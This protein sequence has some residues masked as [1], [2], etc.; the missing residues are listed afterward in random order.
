MR[1]VVV[2][3][4]FGPAI[5]AWLRVAYPRGCWS[6]RGIRGHQARLYVTNYDKPIHCFDCNA[7]WWT[8]FAPCWLLSA[9]FYKV[10]WYES[11]AMNS[12]I[13][14]IFC[15]I[16]ILFFKYRFW[17]TIA[18]HVVQRQYATKVWTQPTDLNRKSAYN[19]LVPTS[20]IAGF[21]STVPQRVEG[22]VDLGGR[23]L[24]RMV[25]PPADG[26]PSLYSHIE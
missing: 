9:P 5:E 14:L 24:T 26:Y 3:F 18:C 13:R 21:Y 16:L 11:C 19:Q 20:S 1:F 2:K 17:S 4:E 8:I 6:V 25:Y 15:L 23:L 12:V 22:W 7:L 10:S